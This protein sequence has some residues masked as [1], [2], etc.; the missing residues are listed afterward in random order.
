[1]NT[2][3]YAPNTGLFVEA[4]ANP[5]TIQGV[6]G[7]S[8]PRL[9]FQ[10]TLHIR[11][12]SGEHW[13]DRIQAVAFGALTGELV[14]GT[15]IVANIRPVSLNKRRLGSL[16]YQTDETI[17][18]EIE[19]DER[20]IEW[21]DQ[22]RAGGALD[23]K[24]R[25]QL[26]AHTFGRTTNDRSTFSFGLVDASAIYGEIPLPIPEAR[27]REQI[28]PGL[29]FGT[30]MV[31]ELPT[32]S[33]ESCEALDHSF[34][35]LKKAQNHFFLGLYDDAVAACRVALDQFFEP[36]DKNDGSGKTVPKLKKS[37]ETQLGAATHQWLDSALGAIKTAANKPHHTPHNH[38]DRFEA[39]MLMMVTTALVAYM[40]RHVDAKVRA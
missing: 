16:G 25:L 37:W 35:A 36:A 10:V 7:A 6:G 31:V 33:L 29:G 17:T 32:F 12:D 28:L 23:A 8:F 5:T 3:L 1:M 2:A 24:L 14:V 18:V 27:W 26:Q 11:E 34:K 21:L 40:A 38:F 9:F 20:R 19:L 13:Q 39:Q 4:S 15:A 30:A 22:L